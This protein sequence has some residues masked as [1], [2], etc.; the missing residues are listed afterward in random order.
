MN[1]RHNPVLTGHGYEKC[2][3]M[4]GDRIFADD[5]SHQTNTV[6]PPRE[7]DLNGRDSDFKEPVVPV[8]ELRL[9]AK[10]RERNSGTGE[11]ARFRLF[12]AA[13]LAIGVG[14][15][16][17]RYLYPEVDSG[18]QVVKAVSPEQPV[19]QSPAPQTAEVAQPK[20]DMLS[21][22]VAELL[23]PSTAT[24]K[25]VSPEQPVSQSPAPQTAEVAQPKIDML[26]HKVAE[27]LH[28]STAT[29]ANS[30]ELLN[31]RLEMVVR[32]LAAVRSSIEQLVVQQEEIT[33]NIA[34]L[35]KGK[36]VKPALLPQPSRRAVVSTTNPPPN[37]LPL[38]P[39]NPAA[40][41]DVQQPP[42]STV[43][44]DPPTQVPR[45]PLAVQ[46]N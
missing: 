41:V 37:K 3:P 39:A 45:P 22:K 43:S 31:Q 2:P 21:H 9:L 1:V 34:E 25:A 33:R 19:S 18:A 5:V 44:R 10:T 4:T 7:V 26:S 32:D 17:A 24:V 14:V 11:R 36:N 23:P 27:L 46:R 15:A 13:L 8:S 6:D 16:V 28:P 38:Q 12:V 42:T 20:I 29:A 35:Q 30:A 40:N